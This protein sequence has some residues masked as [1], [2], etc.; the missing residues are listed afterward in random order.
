MPTY[1]IYVEP[2]KGAMQI[3][4]RK[5][6]SFLPYEI[7]ATTDPTVEPAEI[8]GSDLILLGGWFANPYT[9]KYFV[10][11]GIITYDADRMYGP[12]VY[13][14]GKRCISTTVRANGTTVTAV[15]GWLAMDT[16][17]AVMDFVSVP[18]AVLLPALACGGILTSVAV[19]LH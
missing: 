17:Y 16:I 19:L 5:N 11:T 2:D 9:K 6:P 14:N 8:A 13:A 3:I 10:D 1:I 4:L 18:L 12:G 15:F 7:T